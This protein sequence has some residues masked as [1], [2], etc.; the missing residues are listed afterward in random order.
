MFD[1]PSDPSITYLIYSLIFLGIFLF[2]SGLNIIK[3]E[4]IRVQAGLKTWIIGLVFIITGALLLT[5]QESASEELDMA[6]I[7]YK[8]QMTEDNQSYTFENCQES[9]H[10]CSSGL[11]EFGIYHKGKE[12][13]MALQRCVSNT[14]YYKNKD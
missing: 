11:T 8:K 10:P 12:L 3:V 4:K 1:I 9:T 5:Y 13:N 7:C 14:P 6:Y 2:I